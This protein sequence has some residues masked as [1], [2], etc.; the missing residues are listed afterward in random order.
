M[1]LSESEL[2]YAEHIH[3]EGTAPAP[4]TL[5]E[6]LKRE[7]RQILRQ[8]LAQCGGSRVKAMELLGLSKTVFYGKLKVPTGLNTSCFWEREF[9]NPNSLSRFF[10]PGSGDAGSC[11][12]CFADSV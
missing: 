1:A 6:R 11:A 9:G 5:K 10:H 7:E 3:L 12:P 8:T 2:I 4:L